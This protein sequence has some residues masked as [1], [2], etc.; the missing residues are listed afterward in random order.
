MIVVLSAIQV[1]SSGRFRYRVEPATGA[2]IVT[3]DSEAAAAALLSLGIERAPCL[4][5]HARTWV[6]L[7]IVAPDPE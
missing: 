6:S 7:E 2:P 5:S 3:D 4:I 1:D